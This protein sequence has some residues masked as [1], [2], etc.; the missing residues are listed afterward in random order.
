M[1]KHDSMQ[2]SQDQPIYSEAPLQL[3]LFVDGRPKSK[4]QVQRIRAYLKDLQA[5]YNFELQII[6][7]GQQPYL[8]EHFK[9]VATPALIKIHPEPRQILAGSNIITQL[10][11][12]W[13]RWQAAVDTYVKLQE[14]L[15]ERVDDNG[16][17]AQP[18]STINSVAVSAELLRLS[19]EIFNLKQEKEKLL[20]QLQFK[21]RVIAMLVHD[22][23]N[24]LTAA[25]IAIET[26]QSNYNPDIGQFQRLKPAL[27]VNLLRQARTQ[28]KTIDKMIADLLQVGRGTDTELIIIPQKTEIGLLCLE[29]LGELR[30]RYTTKAQKVETDIPQDLPCV[31]ADP[32]R[33]RQVLINLLDNAIKYTPEG[34][35]ISIA[36]LHRTTQKVQFSIGDT[37]PGIPTDNRERIFENHYR[38]E[39]DEAKEGYGIGLSLCQ[40]IIRAH[41]GQIWVDSNP[42]GGAWFHFTLP[43]YPS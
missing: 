43:V 35:T 31:Y 22:L 16:R 39:R 9:L 3:L 21:D 5:E 14:D 19:D 38:L 2:V 25:A 17:V 28:A 33:I 24:P 41:Y 30:D 7:V 36:G 4:Q 27:V 10:K 20:E 18:T 32:E 1:L 26:L 6:D 11:N 37:G 12:L 29:V 34:G 23:R 15:Q 8:A 13:P 42:H 40:R